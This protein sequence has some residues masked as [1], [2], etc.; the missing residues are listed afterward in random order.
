MKRVILAIV[1]LVSAMA[2]G[3]DGGGNGNGY[4]DKPDK[5]TKTTSK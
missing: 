5:P 2:V 3:C 1:L 4:G